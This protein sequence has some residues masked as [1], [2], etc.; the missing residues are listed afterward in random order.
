M[1]TSGYSHQRNWR[2]ALTKPRAPKGIRR[3][4]PTL[5]FVLPRRSHLQGTPIWQRRRAASRTVP[6]RAVISLSLT[7][8]KRARGHSPVPQRG[9]DV[10]GALRRATREA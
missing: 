6:N 3:P 9:E 2:G 1:V 4:R 10:I 8:L 5:L 7:R